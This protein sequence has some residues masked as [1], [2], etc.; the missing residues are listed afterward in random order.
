MIKIIRTILCATLLATVPMQAVPSA[1]KLMQVVGTRALSHMQSR[2]G[3]TTGVLATQAVTAALLLKSICGKEGPV[4]FNRF[5]DSVRVIT[6]REPVLGFLVG[7]LY[8]ATL[9][10]PMPKDGGAAKKAK[11]L[12]ALHRT[13]AKIDGAVALN[14]F[15]LSA[16]TLRAITCFVLFYQEQVRDTL[17]YGYDIAQVHLDVDA[18]NE[19]DEDGFYELHDSLPIC[20]ICREITETNED[21]LC[22]T[23]TSHAH[24]AHTECFR[25]WYEQAR[26]CPG[27]NDCQPDVHQ[28]ERGML[29]KL[30]LLL[31]YRGFKYGMAAGTAVAAGFAGLGTLKGISAYKAYRA[32]RT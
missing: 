18:L 4:A 28:V 29:S 5:D 7:C 25:Q 8:P 31:G 19:P 2:G 27:G 6:K 14:S 10:V 17:G 9:G 11:W 20:C 26:T 23:C 15:L 16:L 1:P 21:T 24:I 22:Y 13:T 32:S 12:A 3:I 30:R